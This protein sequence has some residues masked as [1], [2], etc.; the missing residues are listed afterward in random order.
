MYFYQNRRQHMKKIGITL[1]GG[2]AR[3]I[4][5]LGVLKALEEMGIKPDMLSGASAGGIIGGFYAAGYKPEEILEI[6]KKA[7]LFNIFSLK[8]HQ[9]IF[10]MKAFEKIYLKHMP[11][12][13]FESL[14]MPLYVAATD[15][16]KGQTVYFSTG[17]L[18]VALMATSC[19]PVAFQAVEIEG[20]AYFDGG[21]LNNLPIEPLIGLCEAHIGVHVNSIDRTVDKVP[22]ADLIDRSFHLALN[23]SIAE[24]AHKFDLFIE[25]PGMSRFGMFDV[26]DFDQI[27]AVG[28]Y[29]AMGIKDRVEAF[30][31]TL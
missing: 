27:Y 29:Y 17:E 2:G 3:G 22:T 11:H 9:G 19:V 13:S 30:A 18:A 28:Y 1:S 12:N 10:S 26:D 6:T 4:A 5:H 23:H 16:A 14:H 20:V 24:K 31:K 7:D 21:I 25:P 8:F 15:I